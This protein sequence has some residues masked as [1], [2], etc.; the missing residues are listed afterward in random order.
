MTYKL[1]LIYIKTLLDNREERCYVNGRLDGPAKYFYKSGAVE[2]RIYENGTLQGMAVKQ[3]NDGECEERSYLQG[4]LEGQATVIYP[5][6]AKEIRNYTVSSAFQIT[7]K[8]GQCNSEFNS[9][10]LVNTIHK[11]YLVV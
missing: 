5:D 2:T 10:K 3:N 9:S 7:I 4:N 11:Q 1:Q 8:M 6:S